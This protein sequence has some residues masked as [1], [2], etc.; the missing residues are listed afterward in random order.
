[1]M[2]CRIR[3]DK[4]A[5]NQANSRSAITLFYQSL[6][7]PLA[8]IS[9]SFD[10]H[11]KLGA[12]TYGSKK[13]SM[14]IELANIRTFLLLIAALVVLT[15]TFGMGARLISHQTGI[16]KTGADKSSIS[17]TP[18]ADGT[19][20]EANE[21]AV[22]SA[23]IN[24]MYVNDR[25]KLIVMDNQT[26]KCLPLPGDGKVADM[27]RSMEE[28]AVK[29]MP[30]LSRDTVD[31]FQAKKKECHPLSAKFNIPVKYVLVSKEDLDPLFP[32]GKPDRMW[33]LFYKKYP[34]SAG[35]INFSNVGFNRTMTQAFIYTS[36]GCGGLCGA[37]YY[38]LLT[39][40]DEVWS[41]KTKLQVWVS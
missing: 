34:D 21:Y 28:S 2:L 33:S 8:A 17:P 23:V 16:Q 41:I 37:G 3:F 15:I 9:E 11:L 12:E 18:M 13:R 6:A 7:A 5:R 22:Y 40:K 27:I 25:V 1:M 4:W 29:K 38:V 20:I 24:E 30:E 39:K 32:K 35:I 19:A 31:D 14:A 36:N 26:T 10:I